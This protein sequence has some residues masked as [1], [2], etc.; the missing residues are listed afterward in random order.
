M[1]KEGAHVEQIT[2]AGVETAGFVMYR[3]LMYSRQ[4]Q[5]KL[6]TCHVLE[7]SGKQKANY[8]MQAEV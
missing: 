7:N 5:R 1:A 8:W 4:K 3:V 6:S 2:T